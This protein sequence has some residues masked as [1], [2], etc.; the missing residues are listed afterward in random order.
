MFKRFKL[1]QESTINVP[2][3]LIVLVL[4]VLA[5]TRPDRITIDLFCLLLI[6]FLLDTLHFFLLSKNTEITIVT[7]SNKVPKRQQLEVTIQVKNNSLW[8]IPRLHL[9]PLDGYRLALK[10]KQ[11]Y[12]LFLGGLGVKE[13]VLVYEA[14]LSGKQTVGL[15]HI[16]LQDYLGLYKKDLALPNCPKV[17]V[18]PE[19]REGLEIAEFLNEG[20]EE[21]YRRSQSHHQISAEEVVEDLT[22]YKEGDSPRL[23]HWKIFAQKDQLLVRQREAREQKG[24]SVTLILNPIGSAIEE[25]QRYE[26]QDKSITTSLSLCN[27]LITK[28]HQ[29]SFMYYQ[30]ENWIKT[31]LKSAR[32]LQY[33]RE[34]LANYENI[35]SAKDRTYRGALKAFLKSIQT[36][37]G[38]KLVITESVDE[39]LLYYLEKWHRKLEEINL[40]YINEPVN[41]AKTLDVKAWTVTERYRLKQL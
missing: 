33:L 38:F 22:A 5:Y 14:K 13:V 26:I 2:F 4:G 27:E 20:I 3:I 6:T 17:K 8:P 25:E 10:E 15:K 30:E 32:E 28:G 23:I 36:Q 11:N 39:D 29:V 9:A 1:A 18:L 24:E 37:P 19:I 35:A 40:I 16:F 12:C 41:Q 7:I 21:G 34:K 31:S